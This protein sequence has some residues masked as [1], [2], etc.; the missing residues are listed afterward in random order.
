MFARTTLF[1]CD[2]ELLPQSLRN[3]RD[4]ILPI[5]RTLP[6]FRGQLVFANHETG[7]SLT[8]AIYKDAASMMAAADQGSE[9]RRMTVEATN[10][11]VLAVA[12]YELA[13]GEV[14]LG[15]FD[16]LPASGDLKGSHESGTFDTSQDRLP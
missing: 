11:E 13:L 4:K 5:A 14:R 6:G 8:I 7:E 9:L 1:R 3:D 15:A 2:P 12:R 10:A 16:L